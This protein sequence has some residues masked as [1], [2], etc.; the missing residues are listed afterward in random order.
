MRGELS[1]DADFLASPVGRAGR[2]YRI[3][4]GCLARSCGYRQAFIADQPHQAL[5]PELATAAAY[6]PR[7]QPIRRRQSNHAGLTPLMQPMP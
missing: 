1:Q 7:L 5:P 4:A 2:V 3:E 6:S